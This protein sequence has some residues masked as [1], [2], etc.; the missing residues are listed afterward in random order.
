MRKLVI[1]LAA[2]L[3]SHTTLA[4]SVSFNLSLTGSQLTLVNQ[5]DTSAFY[6]AVFRL[7]R[8]GNWAPL[9]TTNR[10]AELAASAS[11]VLA[12]S[13]VHPPGPF[14]ELERIQPIMVRFYDQAGVGFGQLS[15][16]R[17]PPLVGIPLKARYA[18]GTLQVHPP[19][20]T[21]SIRASWI[22][23]SEEEGIGPIRKPV[24]FAHSPKSPLRV[25]WKSHGKSPLQVSTGAG[26]PAV[27]MVHETSQG[28]TL[29]R[30]PHGGLQGREQRAAWLDSAPQLYLFALTA[31]SLA[32]GVLGLQ[33]LR[34]SR[35]SVK[36]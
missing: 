34:R 35:A 12:W 9:E 28:L 4:G 18:S 5:G 33:F 6:P 23:W 32:I 2:L 21:S 3:F 30:V 15:F 31:L 27:V 17:A 29:Q 7:L 22:L 1:A 11:H 14:A 16:F 19:E 24:R 36:A 25:D 13:E 8:D 10:L 26:M 20:G